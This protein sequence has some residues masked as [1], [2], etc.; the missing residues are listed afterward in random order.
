MF[1]SIYCLCIGQGQG[2]MW[3]LHKLYDSNKILSSDLI[4]ILRLS[5]L[6]LKQLSLYV[7]AAVVSNLLTLH[8]FMIPMAG[9]LLLLC[10]DIELNPGPDGHATAPTKHLSICHCNIRSI[11]CCLDKID[12]MKAEF[13]TIHDIITIS[14]TWLDE[15]ILTDEFTRKNYLL[16]GYQDPIYRG[17]SETRGGGLLAWVSDRL[18]AKRRHDLECKV[19]RSNNNKFLLG[20]AYRTD[21]Q[22]NFWT[23]LQMS[24][25]NAIAT[26]ITYVIITG[27]L[28][29]DPQTVHG[30]L[31]NN[32][33]M[34][35]S[36]H[37]HNNEPTRITS[38]S[39]TELDQIISNCPNIINSVQVTPPV[40]YNDH[41]TVS[42]KLVFQ[43]KRERAFEH[44]VWFYNNADFALFRLKLNLF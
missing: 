15:K 17:R 20:T 10:G 29:A 16:T 3:C 33:L 44:Q 43:I 28:N 23:D 42:A 19:I 4:N 18:H 13:C 2:H 26:G 12:H 21:E 9:L 31:L 39:S 34:S 32:F 11:K 22:I 7:N 24:F 30:Q 25:N 35:N 27:D 14:E 5:E 8:K 6:C 37:K 40:S 41:H 38:D 36:L 1:N